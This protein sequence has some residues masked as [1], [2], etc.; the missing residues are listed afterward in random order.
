M[1]KVMRTLLAGLA[2]FGSLSAGAQVTGRTPTVY[3]IPVKGE[4]ESALLYVIRRG[5]AEA[6]REKADAVILIMDTPGGTLQAAGEIVR[7]LQGVTV[8]TYTFVENHAFSAGAIIAMATDHIYMAPG[9]VIGDAMPIMMSPTGGGPQE[10]PEPIQEKMVSGVAAL[11]RSAAQESG[12]DPQLGEKMVRREIEYRI[13]DEIISPSNQLLTLTN[14][15]AEREVGPEK[16]KLL[17]AGTV[18]DVDA[19]LATIGMPDAFKREMVVTTAEKIARFIAAVAPFLFAAGLLGI[20]I[21]IKT[22]GFGLPGILGGVCLALF[23]WGHHIAG[24]AGMEEILL[25]L[26]GLVLVL[27]EVFIFPTVGILGFIGLAMMLLG[28]L[29]AM[30]EQVPNGPW[31]PSW[32]YMEIPVMKLAGG[33]VLIAFFIILFGR[34]LPKNPMFRHLILAS[35]TAQADG[36]AA[37]PTRKSIIGAIGVASSP[38]RPSG[39]ALFGDEPLDVI[40]GGNFIRAGSKVRVVEARGNRIVVEE[41]T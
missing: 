31:L 26:V 13:G 22:P 6:E 5:V 19:L 12:H 25:F 17:S 40:T 28:V 30:V 36:F 39:T 10:M 23:F 16:K 20:Y 35:A 37:A 34:F 7:L 41:V 14:V 11:I 18:K 1:K 8:P 27:V 38:L 3:L 15:E 24:L 4:I 2:L 33:I 9:S 29:M 21:E 32:P